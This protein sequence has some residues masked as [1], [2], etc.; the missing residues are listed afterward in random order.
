MLLDYTNAQA[1]F[2]R[3][4]A[5]LKIFEKA[6]FWLSAGS[7]AFLGGLAV[8]SISLRMITG[9]AVPDDNIIIGD[10][11]VA[12]VALA[13]AT[14]TATQGN[15]VVEVFTNWVGDRGQAAL[16][17]LGSCVGLVMILP[18]CWASWSMAEHSIV[19]MTYYDGLLH[20]PQWPSRSVFFIAFLMMSLRLVLL[21][22]TDIVL[23][24]TGR[25]T[26]QV[27]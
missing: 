25:K 10:L 22:A 20:W 24:F 1:V 9:R 8:F 14:V 11:V 5:A 6:G 7:V 3:T 18:L 23:A 26:E 2:P 27:N 21:A 13:W 16:R 12:I 19:K 15:I 4:N 17:A